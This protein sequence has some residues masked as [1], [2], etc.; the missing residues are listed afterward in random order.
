MAE[1]ETK[2]TVEV[3]SSGH[4]AEAAPGLM[5]IS[6]PMMVW[7]WITFGLMAF[8]LYKVAWKPILK[9]LDRRENQIRTALE[10]A[11]QAREEMAKLSETQKQMLAEADAKARE[12]VE[13]ARNAAQQ[14]ATVIEGKAREEAKEMMESARREIG[15][16]ADK[17]RALL[18]K[19]SAELA[20]GL[21]GRILRENLDN[22]KNRELTDRLMKDL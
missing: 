3:P 5:D 15:T 4:E 10:E 6:G 1:T 21:A 16:E 8:V 9:A 2:A 7:T 18:K 14:A 22:A 19:E 12:V 17:A 13:A 20:V 11:A